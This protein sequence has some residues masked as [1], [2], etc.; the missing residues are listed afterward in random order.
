MKQHLA[1]LTYPEGDG[2]L[3]F[4]VKEEKTEIG[5]QFKVEFI[6]SVIGVQTVGEML[7]Q[8]GQDLV[9]RPMYLREMRPTVLVKE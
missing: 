2:E 9:K 8:V 4:H 7:K 6:V 1:R 3:H 5:T